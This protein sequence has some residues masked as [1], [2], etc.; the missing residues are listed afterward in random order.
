M[1]RQELIETIKQMRLRVDSLYQTVYSLKPL[2][3]RYVL[4][5]DQHRI[6]TDKHGEI[7][8]AF[9]DFISGKKAHAVVLDGV[10]LKPLQV[11][12][13]PELLNASNEL[14]LV[15]S[16]LGKF[17]G[18]LKEETPY[19]NDGQR[20][21]VKDIEP[22]ADTSQPMESSDSHIKDV[23]MIRE[24]ISKEIKTFIEFM[25]TAPDPF[26]LEIK[27]EDMR[28]FHMQVGVIGINIFTHLSQARFYLGAELA[29]IRKEELNNQN[30]ETV[31]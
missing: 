17:L 13:F 27:E 29:R 15:K 1:N 21:E 14:F 31:S 3:P 11:Q 7:Q 26:E 25:D 28:N 6:P 10:E 9:Q 30:N 18:L 23:D 19:K 20:S 8:K 2:Y 24:L 16:W 22:T 12:Q 4:K 5:I